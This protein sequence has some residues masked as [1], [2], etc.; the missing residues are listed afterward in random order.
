MNSL[1]PISTDLDREDLLEKAR[2]VSEFAW[3]RRAE[4]ERDRRLPDEVIDALRASKLMRLCRHKRWGGPEADPMTFLDVGREIARG[5]GALGWLF[6]VLGFHE[7]YM[8]FASEE[9]QKEV[10][11]NDLHAMV[12]D[13]YAVVGQI[14]RVADGYVVNG[15]WRFCSGIEWSSW[16][17]VGGIA[18][19]PDGEH[20]EH[21][22][23]FLPKSECVIIDDWNTMGLRGT[24]S[25]TV[26][27]QKAFVP[28]HRA[29]AMGRIA[30]P[31]RSKVT[32]DGPLWRVPLMTMQGLAILTPSTG[33]A[34][35]MVD[36]FTVWTKARVRPYERNA[37]AKEAPAPQLI[38]AEA[39]TQ[40]D[41]T[42]ALAQ[43]YAQDG[44]DRAIRGED[45]VISDELRAQW[46]S[47]RGYIGRSSIELSDQLFT[48]SGAMALFE[49]HPMQQVFRDIHATGVHIGVD[50]ADAY[51]SRGRVAM[52][53]QGNSFH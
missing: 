44:W 47:W 52:G 12:C 35:R 13:S 34:Q 31:G 32:E 10:W 14:D 2:V 29:F 28:N 46:F 5:S 45:W 19:A 37:P 49:T 50:R 53:F 38:L 17:A 6:S 27:I 20:P 51:T 4:T 41:A 40:W 7:W 16:V 43:K 39:A 48:S 18:V 22:M 26:S 15:N 3:S 42:W 21:I 25:R 36:E 8:S 11:G 23:F 9:L 1:S 24:A 33:L 30:G